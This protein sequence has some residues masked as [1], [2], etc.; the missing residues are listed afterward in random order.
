MCKGGSNT[1]TS[2]SSPPAAVM[3]QYQNVQNQANSVAGNPYYFYPGQMVAGLTPEQT[4]AMSGIGALGSAMANPANTYGQAMPFINAG[5]Q[6]T[7]AAGNTLAGEQANIQALQNPAN[8]YGQ[9]QPFINEASGM[10]SSGASPVSS[11]DINQYMNPY[12]SQV[13]QTTMAEMNQH[14]QIQ[15]QA[16]LGNAAASGALGGNRA[17]IAQSALANQQNM[18]ENAALANINSQGFN[19]ALGA[20]QTTKGQQLQGGFLAGQTGQLAENAALTGL[21]APLQAQQ[22]LAASQ[23]GIGSQYANLGTTAE[24][25]SLGGLNAGLSGQQA[26]FQAGTAAQQQQQN[27]LNAGYGQWLGSVQYPFQNTNF[28]SGISTGIGSLSG[29]TSS[30]TPPKPSEFSQIMGDIGSVAGIA[31]AVVHKQ[32]GR[33]GRA[34]GGPVVDPQ[35]AAFLSAIKSMHGAPQA[36]GVDEVGSTPNAPTAGSS[37][38]PPPPVPVVPKKKSGMSL[39]SGG[40]TGLA[41][42]GSPFAPNVA[43]LGNIVGSGSEIP[44]VLPMAHNANI[45]PPPTATPGKKQQL[46][47]QASSIGSSIGSIQNAYQNGTGIFGM[48]GGGQGVDAGLSASSFMGGSTPGLYA[49]GGRTGYASGGYAVPTPMS[50]Q[51]LDYNMMSQLMPGS[52]VR[53]T[54]YPAPQGEYARG[55]KIQPE[56]PVDIDAQL[57]ALE[58]P[59][60]DR[61]AVFIPSGTHLPEHLPKGVEAVH[62]PEGTLLSKDHRLLAEFKDV[63]PSSFEHHLAAALGYPHTKEAMGPDPR[64]VRAHDG[65]GVAYE[66]VVHPDAVLHALAL[67]ARYAPGSHLDVTNPQTAIKDRHDRHGYATGGGAPQAHGMQGV[68]S[69]PLVGKQAGLSAPGAG[70]FLPGD[71]APSFATPA[72]THALSIPQATGPSVAAPQATGLAIPQ[73]QPVTFA[74]LTMPGGQSTGAI[75][76]PTGAPADFMQQIYQSSPYYNNWSSAT[77]PSSGLHPNTPA[78]APAPTQSSINQMIQTALQ[79]Q[80]AAQQQQLA[81][82]QNGYGGG[83]KRGG[84]AGFAVGGAPEMTPMDQSYINAIPGSAGIVTQNLPPPQPAPTPAMPTELPAP[85]PT[86]PQAT[87][88]NVPQSTMAGLVPS[89]SSAPTP[90]G[91]TPQSYYSGFANKV[92]STESGNDPTA[93]NP[94]S[95]AAGPDQFINSTWLNEVGRNY[96]AFASHNSPQTILGLRT[97][98]AFSKI[99]TEDSAKENG[100]ALARAGFP[101][102][103]TNLDLA[104]HY[105]LGGAETILGAP[106]NTPAAKVLPKD[107]IQANPGIAGLTTGQL[108]AKSGVG[109]GAAAASTA[110]AQN[111]TSDVGLGAPKPQSLTAGLASPF[112]VPRSV[113]EAEAQTAQP[114]NQVH[115]PA[116]TQLQKISQSPWLALA[117]AGF[118]MMAGTSPF[119]SV[120]IGRGLQAGVAQLGNEAQQQRARQQLQ[121]QADTTNV[122][123]QIEQRQQLLGAGQLGNTAVQNYISGVHALPTYQGAQ[124]TAGAVPG[125][126]EPPPLYPGQQNGDAMARP[127]TPVVPPQSAEQITGLPTDQP[128]TSNEVLGPTGQQTSYP[129]AYQEAQRLLLSP[130]T[131]GAAH[132][133]LN[134]YGPQN[135]STQVNQIAEQA[136]QAEVQRQQLNELKSATDHFLTGPTAE[137]RARFLK[138]AQTAAEALGLKLPDGLDKSA[139]ASQIIP[140]VA[141][142]IQSGLARMASDRGGAVVMHE[143][144]AGTPN[145]GNTRA[146]IQKLVSLYD[147]LADRT[148]AMGKYVQQMVQSGQMTYPM[149]VNA[150]NEQYPPAMWSS[151][152]DPMP[153]PKSLN[154][155]KAGYVY[156]DGNRAFM[157]NGKGWATP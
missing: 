152:V 58:D 86:P 41:A 114:V 117:D 97:N 130:A 78:P 26:A 98:P 134:A 8:T 96:P 136:S 123:N 85:P 148:N 138:E 65:R 2:V 43:Q 25:A 93:T 95:S 63:S 109:M 75:T 20:A 10:I 143:V 127:A 140:K 55:G 154:Q 133:W 155:L 47:Q 29:G 16:L 121:L 44:S 122:R 90:G 104:H 24:N 38:L 69:T 115:V 81:S 4:S 106:A 103:Y 30:T 82:Q 142:F 111:G 46:A 18:A 11:Q 13:G 33:V 40:R 62:R 151:R 94:R 42:G 39:A 3:Q 57:K 31:A 15:Q 92:A 54:R 105:G 66:A 150:F 73:A 107:V 116:T 157:W 23:Q 48:M 118:A 22:N 112:Q 9:A 61:R 135:Y 5:S 153:V 100:A 108:I 87:V 71:T 76:N 32:G 79:K 77:H 139:T 50:E 7:G 131:A 84:R 146:G 60:S 124:I 27:Q 99:I 12:L 68:S 129:Q 102:S 137:T 34:L 51:I 36:A 45:P 67:A 128:A 80:Q 88:A 59:R 56:A 19:T 119:A 125:V 132:Q 91:V 37:S 144:M 53:K 110:L 149:A 101:V 14:N 21:T 52:Q 35:T 145:M 28:L 72:M 156:Q 70:A 17:G 120:N 147:T 49:A 89:T 83:H 126:A 141:T 113:Q 1:T 64:V 74:P 6:M